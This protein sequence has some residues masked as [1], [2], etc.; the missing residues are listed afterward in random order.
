MSLTFPK[1]EQIEIGAVDFEVDTSSTRAA[2]TK[3]A[4]PVRYGFLIAGFSVAT[5]VAALFAAQH[6]GV[7]PRIKSWLHSRPAVTPAPVSAPVLDTQQEIQVT[8]AAVESPTEEM[9]QPP[10]DQPVAR[11]VVTQTV[12]PAATVKTVPA[13][14]QGKSDRPQPAVTSKAKPAGQPI[15][16]TKPQ[17]VLS[18]RAALPPLPPLPPT[19]N[20][21]APKAQNT[22]MATKSD[23]IRHPDIMIP[24]EAELMFQAA[25]KT[26]ESQ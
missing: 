1:I 9:P 18:N 6:F 13:P 17:E 14:Q 12:A 4:A 26:H 19:A 22:R 24:D 23:A 21:P 5:F 11:P 10:A 15:D 7:G 8:P 25:A 3:K 20:E 16:V 2:P